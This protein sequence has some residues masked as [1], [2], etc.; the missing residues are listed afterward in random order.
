M[1]AEE[2]RPAAAYEDDFAP[3]VGRSASDHDPY[4]DA[5]IQ[6]EQLAR[7]NYAKVGS[8]RP[9]SLL[10]THGPGAIVDLPHFTV[11]PS[12][13][14]FW[15][16]IWNRRAG[17]PPTIHAP[18]LLDTAR[19]FLGHQVK[20]LRPYPRQAKKQLM[21]RDGDDLGVPARV[22]PQMLRCT[23]CDDLRP[24][25]HFDYDNSAFYRPDLARFEHVG[26]SGRRRNPDGTSIPARQVERSARGQK[27]RRSPAIPARYLLV[28]PD[29]HLDEFPYSEW[30][31][32]GGSCKPGIE[33]PALKMLIGPGG[34]GANATILC[35]SCDQKRSMVEAQG[36]AGQAKL[37]RCR[38][39]HPHLE[40][41]EEKGC[42]HQP[43]VML[44]GAANL[45]FGVTQSVIVMPL[46]K[47]ETR[48]DLAAAI[49]LELGDKLV[50]YASNIDMLRDLLEGRVDLTEAASDSDLEAVVERALVPLESEESRQ[51]RVARWD[52]VELLAPEWNYLRDFVTKGNPAPYQSEEKSGLVL[53]LKR[54]PRH[55]A[56]DVSAVV[57][58]DRLRKVN[59]FLGFTR[60]DELDRVG[61]R[62]ARLV[63]VTENRPTWIVATEDR[64][65]G[66]FLSLNEERVADWEGRVLAR[67]DIVWPA[68]REAH[69]RNFANR[70]SETA[71]EN[72]RENARQAADER[73]PP[74]RYWLLHS[75]SH[76]LIREMAL[77]AGY[78][79]ASLTE[80]IYAYQGTAE[81]TPAA[82]ILICTTASDSDG[83]LGGLVRLSDD[84][85]LGSLLVRAL[86][87]ASRCSSDPVCAIRLPSEPEDFLHGAACHACLMASETS[88]ERANRFLDRRFLVPLPGT[89]PDLAFFRDLLQQKQ[90]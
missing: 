41:F 84:S 25:S 1:T 10:Y 43:R 88:C 71:D 14:D 79:A 19:T 82:G 73:F 5:E 49:R 45:W 30:V 35:E 27:I 74:P 75:L 52:P 65:E 18:R 76:A 63:R 22:F 31:H 2:L 8:Q 54:V 69:V 60:I 7:K 37:P 48:D 4:G 15:D 40:G 77:H 38:G 13:Y 85:L 46:S 20:E 51:E 55:V 81:R 61:D 47:G 6:D 23:G 36:Q 72:A 28:C 21:S 44:V 64:G 62:G 12:G 39:R 58:V 11:M 80:R 3:L 16:R 34:K 86:Q 53:S 59:A 83:T 67:D 66:V 32:R 9:T 78:G 26:C 87:R 89:D 42:S 33:V 17:E 50:K 56:S 24:L 90:S 68:H 57:A 70:L 29:G